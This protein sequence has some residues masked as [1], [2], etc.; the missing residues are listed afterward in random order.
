MKRLGLTVAR[1]AS[2]GWVG[3][4]ALFVVTAVR[5]VRHPGFDSP[6]KDALALVRFPAFYA[7]GFALVAVSLAGSLVA[8]SAGGSARRRTTV[9]A[10]LLAAT[11]TVMAVDNT[12][13][14]RPMADLIDPPGKA[15]TPAFVEYHRWSIWVNVADLALCGA[16][17]VVLS[18]PQPE[19][20]AAARAGGPAA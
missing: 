17:A 7:F 6:T 15:R 12:A 16:A 3:A 2:A 19:A 14:Y 9:G 13:V 5:E 8:V 11:L 1:V 20:P 10:L 4:A 18:W